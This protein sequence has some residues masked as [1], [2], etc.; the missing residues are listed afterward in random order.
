MSYI[1]HGME[2]EI[3]Y[4]MAE[5]KEEALKKIRETRFDGITGMLNIK[6]MLDELEKNIEEVAEGVDW[7]FGVINK[8]S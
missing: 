4:A 5:T 1:Q 7:Y 3:F 2:C 8:R 6:S